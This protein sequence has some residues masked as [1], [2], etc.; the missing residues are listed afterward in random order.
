MKR[1]LYIILVVLAVIPAACKKQIAPEPEPE[2][3]GREEFPGNVIYY[4]TVDDKPLLL[5]DIKAFSSDY[6]ATYY[7]DGQGV[8]LF[9]DNVETINAG[10]FNKNDKLKS[11]SLSPHIKTIGDD[12]FSDCENLESVSFSRWANLNLIGKNA[13]KGCKNLTSL[14][15]ECSVNEIGDYAFSESSVESFKFPSKVTKMGTGVMKDCKSLTS[16]VFDDTDTVIGD[17][18]FDGCEKLSSVILPKKGKALGSY[19]FKGCNNVRILHANF[20]EI[21]TL[22]EKTFTQ[23]SLFFITAPIKELSDY[24][25]KWSEWADH[26][27]VC[28]EDREQVDLANWTDYMPDCMPLSMM[29]IPAAHDAATYYAIS[30]TVQA[31]VVKDQ[32]L[33]YKNSWDWGTRMYDLRLGYDDL[34]GTYF[35]HSHFSIF[36][37]MNTISGDIRGGHFPTKDQIKNSF[38]MME[39]QIDMPADPDQDG[40]DLLMNEFTTEILKIYDRE[41][42]VLYHPD[43][44]LGEAR[45]KIIMTVTD[46][47]STHRFSSKIEPLPIVFRNTDNNIMTPFYGDPDAKPFEFACQNEWEVKYSAGEKYTAITSALD[48][49]RKDK[50]RLPFFDG[51]N[52]AFPMSFHGLGSSWDVST[53][54]NPTIVRDLSD[55]TLTDTF[56]QPL[57]FVFYDFVGIHSLHQ[58]FGSDPVFDGDE[59]AKHLVWHNFR[60]V[61]FTY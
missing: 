27:M 26:I 44:T 33:D 35:V 37:T 55:S 28:E 23:D 52:A 47:L 41:N 22:G 5:P 20:D 8:F 49:R 2:P 45:G 3:I 57:G 4:T 50:N 40:A 18:C 12:A 34:D 15:V 7:Q 56:R 21:P 11:I 54:V 38:L 13:F 60:D 14:T 31:Y 16:V 51:F 29:T 25:S 10:A 17:Y 48:K 30:H 46:E 58:Y 39:L 6:V 1:I 19:V 59:L 36:S 9:A 32:D 43:M 24:R 53:F 61:Y 42:F